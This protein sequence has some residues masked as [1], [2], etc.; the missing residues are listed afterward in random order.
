MRKRR[1]KSE[2]NR[3]T[4][5]GKSPSEQ[6]ARSQPQDVRRPSISEIVERIRM[7]PP[8]ES[9]VD[10]ALLIRQQRDGR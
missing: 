9:E 1:D 5:E 6:A 2:W 3:R 8:V 10:A 7:L 4:F